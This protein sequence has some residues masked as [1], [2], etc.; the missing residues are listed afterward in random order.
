MRHSHLATVEDEIV[1]RIIRDGHSQRALEVVCTRKRVYRLLDMRDEDAGAAGMLEEE[2]LR[3]AVCLLLS[4]L[5][6]FDQRLASTL[7]VL[8]GTLEFKEV[9][10][11]N[12]SWKGGKSLGLW[13]FSFFVESFKTFGHASIIA[14]RHKVFTIF[15]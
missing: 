9:V 1:D 7:E 11:F 10:S 15:V 2:R 6:V 13:F 8:L 14:V 4:A 3:F 12:E 5:E